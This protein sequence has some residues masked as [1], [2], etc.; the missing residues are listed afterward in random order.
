MRVQVILIALLSL[1]SNAYCQSDKA[2]FDKDGNPA[3]ADDCVYFEVLSPGT[4]RPDTIRTYYCNTKVLRSVEVFD[5]KRFM[6]GTSLYYYDNGQLEA[7]IP[8]EKYQVVGTAKIWYRNGRQRAELVYMPESTFQ[9]M[10]YWDSLGNQTVD[11]GNGF[12]YGPLEYESDVIHS[13]KVIDGRKDSHWLGFHDDGTKYFEEIYESGKLVSGTSFNEQGE[14]FTYSEVFEMAQPA[15][16]MAGFYSHVGKVIRYP[17]PARRQGV[18]GRVFI[19]FLVEKDGTLSGVK[20]IKGIGGGCDEEAARVVA[21]Y[22]RW[23]PGRQRGQR[24][25][26]KM[27][28]PIMF[29]LTP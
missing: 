26:Q 25:R 14:R 3:T 5:E 20:C 22:T 11:G 13:G 23:N 17:K 7:S 10:N 2:Y 16:G 1:A 19:E 12:C 4:L 29:K 18:E 28:L 27:V 15:E 8:Y 24:V 9:I 21:S 6:Q